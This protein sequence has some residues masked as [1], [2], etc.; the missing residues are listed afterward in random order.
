MMELNL[1]VE[2]CGEVIVVG[3]V[4]RDVVV[5]EVAKGLPW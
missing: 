5:E 2:E 1:L 3:V 4:L